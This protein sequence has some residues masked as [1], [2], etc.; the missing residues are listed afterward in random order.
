M[1]GQ[2]EITRQLKKVY[3]M[4]DASQNRRM[5]TSKLEEVDNG[6]Q[7]KENMRETQKAKSR[8]CMREFQKNCGKWNYKLIQNFEIYLDLF[9]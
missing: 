2:L 5:E 7:E 3:D 9:S 6:T 1:I 8:Y 4:S